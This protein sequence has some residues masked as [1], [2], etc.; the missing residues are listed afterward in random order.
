MLQVQAFP[1]SLQKTKLFKRQLS[2]LFNNHPNALIVQIYSVIK[3]YMF[4]AISFP[5][6]GV[7][8]CTLGIGKF[9]AAFDD[10]MT[11]MK[12]TSAECTVE[13]S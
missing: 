13:N 11:C 4:R 9:H 1:E 6:S 5:S 7:S 8:H 3:L 12:L 2:F 10:R